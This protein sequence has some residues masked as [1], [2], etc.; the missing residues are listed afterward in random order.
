VSAAEHLAQGRRHAAR[1]LAEICDHPSP[2]L[3]LV[4]EIEALCVDVWTSG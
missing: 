1:V 3:A 4:A 2:S